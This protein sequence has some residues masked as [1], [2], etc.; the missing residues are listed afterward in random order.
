MAAPSSQC[1]KGSRV[2]LRKPSIR[3]RTRRRR[4]INSSI[5]RSSSSRRDAYHSGG[6]VSAISHSSFGSMFSMRESH[7]SNDSRGRLYA[8]ENCYTPHLPD[9]RC[10]AQLS[11]LAVQVKYPAQ[12]RQPSAAAT[13]MRGDPRGTPEA[14][15]GILAARSALEK[16]PN[17]VFPRS[18]IV[19]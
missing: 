18:L 11:G 7:G 13:R 3:S 16:C 14:S 5:R 2:D 4:W 10:L 1:W 19:W 6:T 9:A 8:R 15:C 12:G 17:I